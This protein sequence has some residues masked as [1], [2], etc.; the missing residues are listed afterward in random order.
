[1]NIRL[2]AL[3]L[4]SG[5]ALLIA[6]E[7][8]AV[9]I[10]GSTAGQPTFNRPAQ[11]T[12]VD[13]LSSIGT[14]DHYASTTFSVNESGGYQFLSIAI[15]GWDNYLFLYQSSFNPLAPLANLVTGND[16]FLDQINNK[17]VSGFTQSLTA[18][19]KY[20]FVTT[21]FGNSDFG[22]FTNSITGPGLVNIAAVPEPATW[23]S[24]AM[25]LIGVWVARRSRAS[26]R[27]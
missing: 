8:G 6:G 2:A 10:S 23:L 25:G 13:F 24:L 21:G 17:G 16:D 26:N 5:S 11:S 14:A 12:P 22:A 3:A 15:N 7:A 19:T 27:G 4:L 18:G 1:M 9:S 20:T